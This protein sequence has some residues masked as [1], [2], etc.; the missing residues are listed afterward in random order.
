MATYRFLLSEDTISPGG[1]AQYMTGGANRL[2]F[3]LQ[4][5]VG[6][7]ELGSLDT[8]EAICTSG[9]TSV[10]TGHDGAMLWRW[11]LFHKEEEIADDVA[12]LTSRVVAE[13]ELE[14]EELS[15]YVFRCENIG[16]PAEDSLSEHLVLGPTFSAVLQGEIKLNRAGHLSRIEAGDCW[17]DD[18]TEAV[19]FNVEDEEPAVVVKGQILAAPLHG[20]AGTRFVDGS[21]VD[22]D[23]TKR[24]HKVTVDQIILT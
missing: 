2:L 21:T 22:E 7:G 11:E 3:C 20:E 16:M 14:L 23:D 9:N 12:G 1:W 24:F 10:S 4:G 18:G 17:F 19:K 13:A 6:L 15:E 5:S 8:H